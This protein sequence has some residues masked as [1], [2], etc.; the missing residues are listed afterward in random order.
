MRLDDFTTTGVNAINISQFRQQLEQD[1]LS[2]NVADQIMQLEGLR[3]QLQ[4]IV[5]ITVAILFLTV[6]TKSK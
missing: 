4:S 3:T 5:S 6:H 2:F 1:I